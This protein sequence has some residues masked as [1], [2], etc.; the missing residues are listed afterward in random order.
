[1]SIEAMKQALDLLEVC[2]GAEIVEGVIIY[3]D[4]EITALRQAIEQA[5]KM[6]PVGRVVSANCEYATV[7]WLRQTSEVGG[8]DPKNSRSWPIAGDAVYTTPQPQQDAWKNAA[9]RLGEELSSVGPDGYYNMTAEQ[10][11]SWALDQ[12]PHGKHS[13]PQPQREWVG[14]TE[15]EIA[16]VCGF[17]QFTSYSTQLTLSAVARA[18][19]AKLKEKNT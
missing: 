5:E 2:N 8:G 6:E 19:E 11:L 1:M 18:I 12:Q 3:T 15:E 16:K 14:L 17:G 4:K 10:W 7:Q 9:I 13:L